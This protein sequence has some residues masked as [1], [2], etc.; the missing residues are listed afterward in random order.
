MDLREWTK[1]EVRHGRR[2]V[3]SGLEGVHSG[4]EAFLNGRHL[5]PFLSE[6]IRSN[7]L[8]PAA[9]EAGIGMLVACSGSRHK[10]IGRMSAFGLLGGA[11]GF[12]AGVVR[13]DRRLAASVVRGSLRTIGRARD[14]YWMKR[15]SIAHA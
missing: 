13:E 4:R 11:I 10:S 3:S 7:A 1:S 14:E 2:L 5:T 8:K 9:L 15:H 6:S 12:G